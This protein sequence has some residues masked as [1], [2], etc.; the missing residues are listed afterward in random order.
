M[1]HLKRGN[2]IFSPRVVKM[3]TGILGMCVGYIVGPPLYW[4]GLAA[5]S[6]SSSSCS[7]C[8]CDCSSSYPFL[9]LPQGLNRS[10]TDCMK[11]DPEVSEEMEKHFADLV[12]DEL[13]QKEAEASE[14][15]RRSDMG[16]LEA[17][18]F[19]SQYQKEADKCNSG[20]ETC[21]EARERAEEA[22]EAQRKITAMWEQ[23]ARQKG[24]NET[25]A[26]RAR[27]KK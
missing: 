25:V 24:W 11:H 27:E 21:E 23:R 20:M 8:L 16:L 6:H 1:V 4:Q 12:A 5:F 17:K 7:P 14:N 22:L 13:R 2:G 19:A 10:F 3:A 26:R 9:S 18:K 15:Q